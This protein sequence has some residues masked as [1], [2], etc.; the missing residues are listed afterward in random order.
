M[1]ISDG[2][3]S[4][5]VCV[6]S[7]VAAAALVAYSLRKMKNEDIPGIAVMTAAFF[8]ASLVHIK[9]GPTSAHLILNGL[10][11]I[12]L[13]IS[14]FPAILV[15]LLFHALM[16]QHG[17]ITTLG[18][19]SIAMGVPALISYGIFRSAGFIKSRSKFVISIFSFIS[20][21][22]AIIFSSIFTSLFLIAA[23]Q[24][25]IETAKIVL[26]VNAPIAIIEGF[27]T[28]FVVSFLQRVKP[29]MIN[30]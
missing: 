18:V 13:G 21:S 6:G 26:I 7:G 27:I 23:G 30:L 10:V 15:A 8:V 11:G 19:N 29:E 14:S 1:H 24:E 22:F 5:S 9:I 16:F 2:V 3:L 25:F 4:G 17:G 20:G 28:L 12:I